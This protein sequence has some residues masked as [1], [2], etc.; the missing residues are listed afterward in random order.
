M[1]EVLGKLDLKMTAA[2]IAVS[3][4]ARKQGLS[5]RDAGWVLGVNRVAQACRDRGWL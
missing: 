3:D 4:L 1:E 2:Y 5:L